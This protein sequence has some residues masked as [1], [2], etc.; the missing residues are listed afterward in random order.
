MR[1]DP[2]LDDLINDNEKQNETCDNPMAL[3]SA[4]QKGDDWTYLRLSRLSLASML[5]VV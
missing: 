1:L 3:A 5:L 4:S 2:D